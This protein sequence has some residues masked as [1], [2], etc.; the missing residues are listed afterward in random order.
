VPHRFDGGRATIVNEGLATWTY[1]G[2]SGTGIAEY[3]HQL[4]EDG[5]PV[6][7]IE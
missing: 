5:T 6:V 2:R 7:P 4:N 1:E 3:L